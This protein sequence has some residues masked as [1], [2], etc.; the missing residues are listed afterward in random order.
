MLIR[1]GFVRD[2]E[3]VN[4]CFLAVDEV[5]ADLLSILDFMSQKKKLY[6]DFMLG[7]KKT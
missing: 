5:G 2:P 3:N 6:E 4:N 7:R 1:T